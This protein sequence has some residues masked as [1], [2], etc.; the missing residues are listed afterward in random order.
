MGHPFFDEGGEHAFFSDNDLRLGTARGRQGVEQENIA[1]NI[2]ELEQI[3]STTNKPGQKERI[4]ELIE[5]LKQQQA[6]WTRPVDDARNPYSD[7]GR[8]IVSGLGTAAPLAADLALTI[9]DLLGSD[10]ADRARSRLQERV[11]LIQETVDPQGG[12]GL[13]GEFAGGV[14]GSAVPYGMVAQGTGRAVASVFPK[15]APLLT[16]AVEGSLARKA[17]AAAAGNVLAGA[18]LNAVQAAGMEGASFED[19]A[20]VFTL[21]VGADALFGAASPSSPVFTPKPKAK[22]TPIGDNKSEL[23]KRDAELL[24]LNQ[25]AAADKAEKRTRNEMKKA[26]REAWK[27]AN[28]DKK[29]T[30]LKPAEQKALYD[31]HASKQPKPEAPAPAPTP[32]AQQPTPEQVNALRLETERLQR[33][34]AEQPD[35]TQ[36]AADLEVFQN[37]TEKVAPVVAASKSTKAAIAAEKVIAD[38][39]PVVRQVMQKQALRRRYEEAGVPGFDPKKSIEE[40]TDVLSEALRAKNRG[41]SIEEL[42][43]VRP[44]LEARAAD[45]PT[46]AQALVELDAQIASMGGGGGPIAASQSVVGQPGAIA[47][48]SGSRPAKP[49]DPIEAKL[50]ALKRGEK[51]TPEPKA[52]TDFDSEMANLE[53]KASWEKASTQVLEEASKGTWNGMPVSPTAKKL[54]TEELAKRNS[55]TPKADLHDEIDI[56]NMDDAQ[57]RASLEQALDTKDKVTALNPEARRAVRTVLNSPSKPINPALKKKLLD[58]L[59][60]LSSMEGKVAG[61]IDRLEAQV[62]MVE[63]GASILGSYLATTGKKN[64]PGIEGKV[65]GK[66]STAGKGGEKP[67][68]MSIFDDNAFISFADAQIGKHINPDG[69][70]KELV[71]TTPE[72]DRIYAEAEKRGIELTE[73]RKELY[74]SK[75]DKFSGTSD[76]GLTDVYYRLKRKIDLEEATPETRKAMAEVEAELRKRD[77]T[78]AASAVAVPPSPTPHSPSPTAPPSSPPALPAG[79]ASSPRD[80]TKLTDRQLAVLDDKL[81]KELES[82]SPN[83]PSYLAK[84]KEMDAVVAESNK[85]ETVSGDRLEAEAN[86]RPHADIPN[87]TLLDLRDELQKSAEGFGSKVPDDLRKQIEGINAEINGRKTGKL[88]GPD[89]I[90]EAPKQKPAAPQPLVEPTAESGPPPIDPKLFRASPSRLSSEQIDAQIEMLKYEIGSGVR[91]GVE[92]TRKT[93]KGEKTQRTTIAEDDPDKIRTYQKRLSDLMNEQTKRQ[94]PPPLG[95]NKM[96]PPSGEGLRLQSHPAVGAF[97]GG[98]TYGLLTADDDEDAQSRAFMWGIGASGLFVGTKYL[99]ARRNAMQKGKV[100]NLL[101]SRNQFPQIVYSAD[102]LVR[103]RRPFMQKM[104]SFYQGVVDHHEGLETFVEKIGRKELPAELNPYKLA[105]MFGSWIARTE[106]FT[107]GR[108]PLTYVENGEP[109]PITNE[110]FVALGL[111][112]DPET[113][114]APISLAQILEQAQGDKR[115]LDDLAVAYA[116]VEGAGR[117]P[118]PM[119]VV[120]RETLIREAD[121]KLRIAVK[122][123]RKY[124]LALAIT[125]HKSGRI[126]KEGLQTM[127]KEDWYTPFHRLVDEIDRINAKTGAD[128]VSAPDPLKARGAG[129]KKAVRSPYEVSLD[130]TR[131]ML[132]AAEYGQVMESFVHNVELLPLA[133]QRDILE[134]VTKSSSRKAMQVDQIMTSSFMKSFRETAKMS[135]ADAKSLL[136]YIDDENVSAKSGIVTMYRNGELHSYKVKRPDI[137]ESLKSLTPDEINAFWRF[138]GAPTRVAARGTV[139]NP[140]FAGWQFFMDNWAVTLNSKYGFRPGW[141]LV[142]GW[143]H[144]MSESPEYQRLIDVGGPGSVAQLDYTNPETALKA[145]RTKGENVLD[146]A[147][148]NVKEFSPVRAYKA[149]LYPWIEAP[150]VGEY[151][152]ALDHGASTLE[153]AFAAHDVG[154]N[155]RMQGSLNGVRAFHQMTLFSRPALAAMTKAMKEAGIG[156]HAPEYNKTGYGRAMKSIGLPRRPAAALSFMAKGFATISIP[157]LIFWAM[158]KDDEEIQQLR[159]TVSGQR[160]WFFRQPDGELGRVRKPHVIGQVF[161][162]SVENWADN[163]RQADP[164]ALDRFLETFTNDISV[165]MLP[166]IGVVPY[167]LYA[168]KALGLGFPITPRKDENLNPIFQGYDNASLPA[169]VVSEKLKPLSAATDSDM[170]RRAMSP[171]GIDY[172]TGQLTGMLGQDAVRLVGSAMEYANSGFLP[173]KD[174]LP[175]IGRLVVRYPSMNV[176]EVQTFYQRDAKVMETARTIDWYEKRDP[177]ALGDYIEANMHSVMMIPEHQKARQ[178]VADLRRAIDDLRSMPSGTTSRAYQRNLEADFVK[179]IEQQLKITNTIYEATLPP[180]K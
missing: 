120:Q 25:K 164:E 64:L 41:P 179:L 151:L 1:Q 49:I 20:K 9:P 117:G 2:A 166:Q 37:L 86:T 155:M 106:A 32:V 4:A 160:Y 71:N 122:E 89:Q 40:L 137:F 99:A 85:R 174:E 29:W 59:P 149:F 47:G 34:V 17:A 91:T 162:T 54:A 45:S 158:Y 171:A 52:S 76:A 75:G 53:A 126:S 92:V 42:I 107:S 22:S 156:A 108:R 78:K 13:M 23:L 83:D 73:I 74:E 100:S 93:S 72:L 110:T 103:P 79:K 15:A 8:G 163:A 124:N 12:A 11:A 135:E 3:A 51:I 87:E 134:P 128:K 147:V 119:D 111:T 66:I 26:A 176:R 5:K 101:P 35:N 125:L 70:P 43:A 178:K 88:R 62:R 14:A 121:P 96:P 115:A 31:L 95:P 109:I 67:S 144:A 44:E 131:R 58:L 39:N 145:L 141:D 104:R 98:Y 136:A 36:A 63:D 30:D 130:M 154:G 140:V 38:Q 170:L 68:I 102:D 27:A 80:L 114:P 55:A 133:V 167:S 138:I 165:N 50:A 152:R 129:S 150:R 84:V 28:P 172:V 7:V 16:G 180:K 21:G 139:L 46:H 161:G 175:L 113:G 81:M 177:S 6:G 157:S 173:P 159:R 77:D 143:W 118:V 56:T 90:V 112:V 123:L 94:S 60:T 65:V 132:R 168:N 61:S 24:A 33:T 153:A 148:R 142:R 18:P 48:V 19:K 127:A 116:S 97:L 82:L 105:S 146:T 69:T 57:I 169:R 10:M